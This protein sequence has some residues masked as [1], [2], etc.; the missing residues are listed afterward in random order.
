MGGWPL[1]KTQNGAGLTP[2][3]NPDAPGFQI[4]QRDMVVSKL[5]WST[6]EYHTLGGFSNAPG[7]QITA[8]PLISDLTITLRSQDCSAYKIFIRFAPNIPSARITVERDDSDDANGDWWKRLARW[9]LL[10]EALIAWMV[11]HWHMGVT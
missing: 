6:A 9:Q 10:S 2:G 8:K 5:C 1:N 11:N 4:G 7:F 3:A